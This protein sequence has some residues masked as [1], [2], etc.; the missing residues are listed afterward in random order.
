VGTQ[1]TFVLHGLPSVTQAIIHIDDS[2]K[3]SEAYKLLVEGLGMGA[4]MSTRGTKDVS[5]TCNHIGE[6]EKTLGTEA[7]RSHHCFH[8]VQVHYFV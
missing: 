1:S 5:V 7:A 3:G 6:V 2:R 4:V 8:D